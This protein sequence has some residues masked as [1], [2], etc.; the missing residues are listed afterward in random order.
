ML[1]HIQ[2]TRFVMTLTYLTL[3]MNALDLNDLKQ[4]DASVDQL[5]YE[6]SDFKM[7]IKSKNKSK[8]LYC[9][10]CRNIIIYPLKYVKEDTRCYRCNAILREAEEGDKNG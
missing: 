7:E 2:K 9:R 3:K 1:D 8:K 6:R 5:R 10:R 4:L